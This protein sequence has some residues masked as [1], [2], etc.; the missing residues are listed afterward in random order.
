MIRL[1][2]CVLL[3]VMSCLSIACGGGGDDG[4]PS[5]PTGPS[6]SGS[7]ASAAT[8]TIGA[9]GSVSP[10]TVSIPRGSR[11]TFVNDHTQSHTM[12]SN[13][14]PVHNDCPPL[15]LATLGPGQSR[16]SGILNTAR[17]CGFH[18]HDDPT[19]P[20]LMGTVTVQ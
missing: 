4:G 20:G 17:T 2:C 18:D 19:N 8:I 12:S 6:G 16:E 9:S 3:L 1:Q 14:H 13:P 5:T 15:N 10:S 7:G 11:V